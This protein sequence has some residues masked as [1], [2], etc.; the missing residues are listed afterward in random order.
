MQPH[1]QEQQTGLIGPIAAGVSAHGNQ[2]DVKGFY[3]FKVGWPLK[4]YIGIFQKNILAFP[5]QDKN[6]TIL[7]MA[8]TFK[9][10]Y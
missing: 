4:A 10:F 8:T 2:K 5:S 6:K 9:Y 1:G 3:E 7:K